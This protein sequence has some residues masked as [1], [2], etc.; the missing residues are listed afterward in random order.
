[1]SRKGCATTTFDLEDR[2]SNNLFQC[3]TNPFMSDYSPEKVGPR[4]LEP[5]SFNDEKTFGSKFSIP[6]LDENENLKAHLA[7]K[8]AI[9]RRFYKEREEVIMKN[10]EEKQ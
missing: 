8:E 2:T 4:H 9:N 10:Y 6:D 3:S 5:K 1:M 7:K